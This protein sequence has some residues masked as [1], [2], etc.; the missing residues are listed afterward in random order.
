MQKQVEKTFYEFKRLQKRINMRVILCPCILII[1]VSL[2]LGSPIP[3]KQKVLF[4][5]L[6]QKGWILEKPYIVIMICVAS[7]IYTGIYYARGIIKLF[8]FYKELLYIKCDAKALHEELQYALEYIPYSLYRTKNKAVR[9]KKILQVFFEKFYIEELNA[10]GL[11][12]EALT[13]MDNNWK[14]RKQTKLFKMLKQNLELNIAYEEGDLKK[15]MNVYNCAISDIKINS[16]VMAQMKFM[17]YQ[18]EEA[19]ELLKKVKG[20]YLLEKV[21]LNYKLGECYFRMNNYELAKESFQFVI[22]NGNTLVYKE[23]VFDKYKDVIG[24]KKGG[25]NR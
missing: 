15:Y 4:F 24:I 17:Q 11:Y 25:G 5:S 16:M 18:Y 10:R 19:I 14:S 9:K 23:K 12:E 2:M 20:R 7:T 3:Y 1:F 21:I 6:W 13:Y 8:D 22:E